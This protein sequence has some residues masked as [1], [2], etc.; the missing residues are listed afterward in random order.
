ME[1]QVMLEYRYGNE[2]YLPGSPRCAGD[3]ADELEMVDDGMELAWICREEGFPK[4]I[5]GH[6]GFCIGLWGRSGWFYQEKETFVD[7]FDRT[8]YETEIWK[9]SDY[10]ESPGSVPALELHFL[11][12]DGTPQGGCTLLTVGDLKQFLG[13][14]DPDTKLLAPSR[15]FEL[16]GS[17]VDDEGVW[18]YFGQDAQGKKYLFMLGN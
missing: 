1:K 17:L 14:V 7:Y 10:Q 3:L 16:K 2:R 15:N 13:T 12:S 5:N 18:L 11:G 9:F 8:D 6:S 4:E